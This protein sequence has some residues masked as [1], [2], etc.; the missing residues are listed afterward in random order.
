MRIANLSSIEVTDSGIVAV[1][2]NGKTLRLTA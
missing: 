1:D 2:Q